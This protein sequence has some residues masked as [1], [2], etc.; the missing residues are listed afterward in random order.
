MTDDVRRFYDE[1]AADY[2]ALYDDWDVTVQRDGVL[3]HGLVGTDSDPILDVAAGM[4]TQAIGLALHGHRVMARDLSS[5]LVARGRAEAARLGAALDFEVG[6]MC[7]ARSDDAGRFG[8]VVGFGNALPHLEGGPLLAALR[9]AW[10][11]L[12][13]GGHFLAAIRD[14][15][16]LSTK[17]PPLEPSRLMGAAPHRR[18]AMQVWTWDPDG[19]VCDIDLF[20]LREGPGG[21]TASTHRTRYHALLRAD[22]ERA[23]ANAGFVAAQ[24]L[25]PEQSGHALPIFRA[26]RPTP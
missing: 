24:W 21:W 18:V 23:A 7:E 26:R 1:L 13:P 16:E 3:L 12:R 11:A 4:G 20:V 2:D 6:N 8:A 10:L 19:R 15:D 5:A 25:G 9:A 14:Y 22:L 17:R